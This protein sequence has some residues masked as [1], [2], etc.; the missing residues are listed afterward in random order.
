MADSNCYRGT[1]GETWRS[2]SIRQQGPVPHHSR[3]GENAPLRNQ[4]RGIPSQTG[5]VAICHTV[6]GAV[7]GVAFPH[8]STTC[9]AAPSPRR[10]VLLSPL[11]GEMYV[12]GSSPV[13]PL[14]SWLTRV[15][16]VSRSCQPLCHS[17]EPRC[18]RGD[19]ESRGGAQFPACREAPSPDSSSRGIGTPE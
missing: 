15:C 9:V 3:C 5:W 1:S 2:G 13:P 19:E 4:Y 10:S 6:H 17:E 7:R 12:R 8:R 11:V 18:N 16:F 14:C